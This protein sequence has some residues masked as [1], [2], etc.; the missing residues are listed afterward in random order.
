MLRSPARTWIGLAMAL[1]TLAAPSV[2]RGQTEGS[3]SPQTAPAESAYQA[4]GRLVLMHEGRRKPLDTVAR[5]EVKAV[6]G[7]QSFE[8]IGPDGTTG[9]EW[10]PVAALFSWSNAPDFWDDQRF[11]LAEYLPL[12]RMLLSSSID[13]VLRAVVDDPETSEGLKQRVQSILDRKAT[14]EGP[15]G[16]A[17]V[18]ELKSIARDAGLPDALQDPVEA[19]AHR[20]DGH[21]KF[22]SPREL[23][24]ATVPIKGRQVRF[25]QWYID[26][27]MRSRPDPKT[28]IPPTLSTLEKKVGE[29]FNRL[30]RYQ[31]IRGDHGS[32]MLGAEVNV[33]RLVPRPANAK[34]IEFLGLVREKYD[35][36][37]EGNKD[38]LN[39]PSI[40]RVKRDMRD[41]KVITLEAP[42]GQEFRLDQFLAV[43]V[44]VPG[45]DFNPV[46]RDALSTLAEYY[47]DLPAEDRKVPGTDDDAD[48]QL[49]AWLMA[50]ADW[51]PVALIL[52]SDLGQLAQA[53]YDRDELNRFREAILAA[54]ETEADE[55]GSLAAEQAEAVVA[56]TRALAADLSTYPT[57]AEVDREVHYNT[58]APF[59]KAP[60][61]YGLGFALLGLCLMIGTISG[62]AAGTIRKSLYGLGLLGLVGGIGLEIYGFALRILISGWAPVTNLYETVI[63]VALIA[64]VIGLVLEAIYRRVYPAAAAAGVAMLCTIIAANAQ[65]VL[66]PN[67]EALNPI[68]RSNY[69]LTIHVIT[70]VSS[71]AAFALA[72]GLGLI[73]TWFYLTAPY[74]RDVGMGE[75]SRPLMAVPVLAGLG[76][77]GIYGSYNGW[78][79]ASESMISLWGLGISGADILFFGGWA[80]AAAGIAVMVMVLSGLLGEVIARLTLRN[81]RA[82][83]AEGT[84]TSAEAT[85]EA[86]S[87]EGGGTATLTRPSIA[88]IKA[89]NAEMYGHGGD[90]P[91]ERAMRDRAEQVKPI[92]SFVYR[93]LQVGVLLVAAGTILGGVWADYS[94]GRFWGWDPKE[95]SAL[96]TLLVYLIPLHGRFAGWIGS[97]GMTMAAVLCFNSVLMAWYGVNFLLGVGLHSYGFA[98][99]GNQGAVLLSALV[100]SS[101]AFGAIW[102]RSLAKREIT[103]TVAA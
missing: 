73:G 1:A 14:T 50:D 38:E 75:L 96:I 58:F 103:P 79:S 46:E 70:I 22:L 6:T 33:D 26:I 67:I 7:R 32:G 88:A 41:V 11:I 93:A 39:L 81:Q 29:V 52:E 54:K 42:G 24:E 34:Y 31:A 5:Q 95:V 57:V 43:L 40:D 59:Y 16:I 9:P 76:T 62:G 44:D 27:A 37:V 97:F 56:S 21:E 90:D 36:F 85:V 25:D 64:A 87:S 12:R 2:S 49:Q 45:A 94:W 63:W 72:L 18:D 71:Y 100:V 89:R 92:S 82:S 53:G 98:E 17:T 77:V 84:T 30:T 102:R 78:A 4:L 65:S 13:S 86:V 48:E 10:G 74:R 55:P 69:W 68:L 47:G 61:Y 20:I 23:E 99:G 28:N 80:L 15:D 91:R 3:S 35:A 19:L 101:L 8:P 83:A 66:N 60:T 51:A